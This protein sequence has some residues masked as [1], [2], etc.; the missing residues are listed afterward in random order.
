MKTETGLEYEVT[1][2]TFQNVLNNQEFFR[3]WNDEDSKNAKIQ[4]SKYAVVFLDKEGKPFSDKQDILTA[5]DDFLNRLGVCIIDDFES[6]RMENGR[7]ELVSGL[8][9]LFSKFK[10]PHDR[11]VISE[12]L[13]TLTGFSL[14]TLIDHAKNTEIPKE[15]CLRMM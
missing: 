8:G 4:Q 1:E 11:D 3:S 5:W 2:Y 12:T 7:K 15:D 9:Y 6:D 14:S 13:I 10:E